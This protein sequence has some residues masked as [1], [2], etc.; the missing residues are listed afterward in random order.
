MAGFKRI[1]DVDIAL[2]VEPELGRLPEQPR[3]P[4]SHIGAERAS[5]MDKLV[6]GLTRHANPL[7]QLSHRQTKIGHE[8]FS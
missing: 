6:H 2:K 3:E 7:S 4:Q 5:L 8:L 1:P